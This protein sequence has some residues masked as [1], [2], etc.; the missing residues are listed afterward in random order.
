MLQ[1]EILESRDLLSGIADPQFVVLALPGADPAPTA[2]TLQSLGVGS[3]A[4]VATMPRSFGYSVSEIEWAA[5]LALFED[6][7]LYRGTAT[8]LEV[9]LPPGQPGPVTSGG[10]QTTYHCIT[11]MLWGKIP[12]VV[13]PGSLSPADA[14][15]GIR[16][17]SLAIA[18]GWFLSDPPPPYNRPFPPGPDSQDQLDPPNFFLGDFLFAYLLSQGVEAWL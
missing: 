2:R 5:R 8:V 15:P 16:F 18:A 17:D 11:D 3:V 1:L 4:A 6:Q 9:V 12:T 14:A 7:R 10:H 13:I